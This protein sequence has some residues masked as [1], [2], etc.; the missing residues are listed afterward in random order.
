MTYYQNIRTACVIKLELT[1]NRDETVDYIIS[2]CN[3]LAQ[4]KFKSR[5]EWV[6]KVIYLELCK[7]LKF[8][9]TDKWYIYKPEYFLG[10]E[11]HKILKIFEILTDQ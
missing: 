8:D 4:K 2:E 7:R 6:G 10:K 11:T 1:R 5:Y 3:K 9:H